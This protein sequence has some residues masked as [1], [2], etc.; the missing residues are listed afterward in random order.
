MN[1][2]TF[3]LL[4]GWQEGHPACDNTLLLALPYL[5]GGRFYATRCWGHFRKTLIYQSPFGDPAQPGVS[6]TK[7]WPVKQKQ[8]RKLLVVLLVVLP[9]SSDDIVAW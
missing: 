7:N 4:V 5:W 2:L 3:T 9:H 1:Q 8:K 6:L